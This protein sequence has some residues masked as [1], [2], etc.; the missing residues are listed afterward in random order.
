[1]TRRVRLSLAAT[2]Y[3]W[4]AAMLLT[5]LLAEL[6]ELLRNAP[7]QGLLPYLAAGTALWAA[8][9]LV[10][11]AGMWCVVVLPVALLVSA[12]AMVRRGRQMTAV[13][14]LSAVLFVAWRLGTLH[15]LG[16]HG[17]ENP[18]TAPLFLTYAGFAFTL[19]LVTTVVYV[20]LLSRRSRK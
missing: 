1:M 10:V 14:S 17:P 2:F 16:E 11:C 18:L 19:A 12:E 3:G 7:S 20:R 13:A 15:D 4:A 8:F 6:P 9:T 5:L